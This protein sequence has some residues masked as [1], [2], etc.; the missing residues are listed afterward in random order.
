[1]E[2]DYDQPIAPLRVNQIK[3]PDGEFSFP[4]V[5]RHLLHMNGVMPGLEY[6]PETP[7]PAALD[8]PLLEEDLPAEMPGQDDIDDQELAENLGTDQRFP[9]KGTRIGGDGQSH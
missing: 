5:E 9:Q 3:C 7:D 4:M 6:A 1:M 2:K 8:A